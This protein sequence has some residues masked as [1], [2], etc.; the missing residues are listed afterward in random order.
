MKSGRLIL[1]LT[2]ALL[3]LPA[4]ATADDQPGTGGGAQSP[5]SGP[6]AA[7]SELTLKRAIE[8]ALQFHPRI[9]Q[10]ASDTSAAEERVGQARSYLGPQAYGVGEYLRSTDNGIG[11]TSY[12]NPDGILPRITGSNHNLP[13][14]DFSQRLDTSNNY[15]GGIA[16]SQF[17]F[18]FGRHLGLV[19]QRQFE[20]RAAA[21]TE[22][23][24]RL[25]IIFE[26]SQRYFAL[27]QAKQVIRVYEKAVEERQYHLHEAEVK[28][29]AGLR[30]EL[31]VYVMQAEVER[32]QLHLVDARNA[33][34]DAKVALDNALG[35]SDRAPA[36][37]LADVLTYSPVTDSYRPLLS[38]AL[39]ARPEV[40]ALENQVK[41]MG[42][43]IAEY[44][45]DYYPT[46]SAVAGYSA[47][48]TG[49]PA[50]NNFDA[51]VVITWPLF[52]SFLTRDE[53]GEARYHQD[54]IRHAI[55]DMRQR[56]VFEVHTA[57]LD[58]QASLQRI[59]R[60]EKA[61]VASRAELELADKRYAAG[62]SN[63]V[64]L[65]D[66]QR[67]Y[68]EDDAAYADALYGYSTAKAAVDKATARSLSEY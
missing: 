40:V 51:G 4:L 35:L 20:A 60:A 6:I 26:V 32:A 41:A 7:N 12:Y 30:P 36:F 21:A 33:G 22:Q 13:A 29:A 14:G 19:S 11:N 10:A 61:L 66:A 42:A 52:N 48:G 27:L 1:L 34:A 53:V 8:I 18:D 3:S 44:N 46:A 9:R 16:V 37:E 67:H 39:R 47:L 49:L 31:D 62:L 2:V 24:A 63:I 50:A 57:F 25:E 58:W 56:I 23:L 45:S 54:A 15:A 28:A 43:Q 17:L 64:E 38:A 59:K 55:E 65:E 5:A 68:T